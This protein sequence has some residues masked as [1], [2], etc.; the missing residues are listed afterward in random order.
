MAA[1]ELQAESEGVLKDPVGTLVA[2]V[3]LDASE[4]RYDLSLF[5]NFAKVFSLAGD[6]A[7]EPLPMNDRILLGGGKPWF[8]FMGKTFLEKKHFDAARE[9]GGDDVAAALEAAKQFGLDEDAILKILKSI[10]M[11]FG[12]QANVFGAPIPGGYMYLSGETKEIHLLLPLMEMAARESGMPFEPVK[13]EGWTALYAMS[14]P[15][16]IV[17]GIKGGVLMVGL[18]NPETMDALPELSDRMQ[19]LYENSDLNGFLHFDA[20]VLRD[21]VLSMLDPEGI[22]AAFVEDEEDFA[23]TIPLVLEGMK[24][25]LEFRSVDVTGAGMER[26]DFTIITED[27]RQEDV[28]A[29]TALAEKWAERAEGDD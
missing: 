13:K 12:G 11:V 5:T 3:G 25:A 17:M 7:Y 9:A 18:L 23:E 10:G 20:R 4:Y 8:A 6:I 21:F 14:D 26:A 22:L 19:S 29:I 16:D 27:V 24:A 2:E 15:V 1:S 28:D